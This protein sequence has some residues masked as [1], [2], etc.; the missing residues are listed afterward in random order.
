MTDSDI[1]TEFLTSDEVKE[2]TGTSFVNVQ[3]DWLKEHN[4]QF[5]VNRKNKVI[6]GRWYAR[7]KLS[8]IMLKEI[9]LETA[10]QPYFDRVS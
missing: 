5:V 4:W 8:G 10:N 6:I 1:T 7:M 2:L 9:P 3:I